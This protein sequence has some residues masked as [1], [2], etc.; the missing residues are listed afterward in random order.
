M[1]ASQRA[2]QAGSSSTARDAA[3][4]E[5]QRSLHAAAMAQAL[6][7]LLHPAAPQMP[8]ALR[9][10]AQGLLATHAPF[11]GDPRGMLGAGAGGGAAGSEARRE[12]LWAARAEKTPGFG[13]LAELT[14]LAAVKSALCALAEQ[15]REGGEW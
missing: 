10:E 5:K 12:A 9:T 14:G 13:K 3:Q 4:S 7:F 1:S 6:A 11:F 15:V 8:A 2:Q